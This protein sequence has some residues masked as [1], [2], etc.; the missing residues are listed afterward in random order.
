MTF[1]RKILYNIST[2]NKETK[3]YHW[4]DKDVRTLLKLLTVSSNKI[5]KNKY[6][7]KEYLDIL[8]QVLDEGERKPNRT[9]IDT[10]SLSGAM[11]RHDMRKGFPL[12]TTKRMPPKT[13]FAE[14]EG[15]IKGITDKTWY[16][17]RGC[18]IWNEW[19][20]P[21]IV[22]YGNDE[23]TKA[24]MAA[25]PDLGPI[26][27]YQWRNFNGSGVDQLKNA[28]ETLKHNPTDRRMIISAW[29]PIQLSE[30]ALPPCHF[31]FHLLSDGK[32]LDLCWSQRSVDTFLG[33]PFNIASYAMLLTLIAKEVHMIPRYL[34]GHLDDVHIYENHLEQVRE[35]LSRK[36]FELP[37]IEILNSDGNDWSIFDWEYTDFNLIN[38]QHHPTIK[39]PVAV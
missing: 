37:T 17:K 35:Q 9:G 34:V 5:K 4:R 32:F 14:L 36:P 22:P 16:Q 15:F 18:N 28:L 38:Y 30:M 3:F 23:A 6:F 29:N 21:T 39:A 24:R 31:C 1:Y 27:G 13:I 10:F 2:N 8:Q 26:Y 33:L 19:C 12:L 11:F 7:M 20:N 25:E